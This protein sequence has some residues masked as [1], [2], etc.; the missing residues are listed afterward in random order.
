MTARGKAEDTRIYRDATVSRK[1]RND[2]GQLLEHLE[3][4]QFLGAWQVAVRDVIDRWD[5]NEAT[6]VRCP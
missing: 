4:H 6:E 2:L 5:N 3:E 1:T